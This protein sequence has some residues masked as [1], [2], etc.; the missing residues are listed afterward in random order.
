MSIN[1]VQRGIGRA[2][3]VTRRSSKTLRQRLANLLEG[4][5]AKRI[6]FVAGCQRSGTSMTY[7]IFDRDP[8]AQV[9][10]EISVLSDGDPVE[11]L[12]LNALEDVRERFRH[13]PAHLIVA[14]PLVESQRLAALLDAFDGSRALWMFRHY[15][16]V[17][18]SNLKRF[19][20]E[21]GF[22]DLQPIFDGDDTNWRTEGLEPDVV[23][24]ICSFDRATL[25]QA[26]AAALF[27]YARNSLLFKD[28]LEQDERVR[29]C[30]YETLVTRP[31]E[32]IRD[33]YRFFERPYPEGANLAQ[34]IETSSLGKGAGVNLAPEIEALCESM[35]ER[36]L[37]L[38]D[39][40]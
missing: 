23:T 12:R 31:E 5:P 28:G 9:F 17:V 26:D 24:M 19:G 27:W 20:A 16:D 38:V 22:N 40:E 34:G 35:H 6:V 4:P 37:S 13:S 32:I 36:L 39:S 30:R 25:T 11:G 2:R 29:A 21:N 10:D 18:N 3:R 1:L 8:G 7:L 33:L 14:K 15:T